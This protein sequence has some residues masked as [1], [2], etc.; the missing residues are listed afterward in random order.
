MCEL[1]QRWPESGPG[2]SSA[3]WGPVLVIT[4]TASLQLDFAPHVLTK[5]VTSVT[6]EWSTSSSHTLT[7]QQQEGQKEP[8][9]LPEFGKASETQGHPD[10]LDKCTTSR[11]K[12]WCKFY[13][14]DKQ[15]SN[16]IPLILHYKHTINLK[17][18]SHDHCHSQLRFTPLPSSLPAECASTST[19]HFVSG[20]LSTQVVNS[21]KWI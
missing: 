19:V 5:W 18:F 6:E 21:I 1:Q 13:Y 20:K 16:N 17:Q 10:I 15:V 8:Q 11:K 7:E 3:P 2:F 12:T 4:S 14:K 9:E